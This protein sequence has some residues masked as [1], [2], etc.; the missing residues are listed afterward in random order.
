MTPSQER[1]ALK[2]IKDLLDA[3]AEMDKIQDTKL[4]KLKK[5]LSALEAIVHANHAKQEK[6]EIGISK[7]KPK[8]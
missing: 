7:P 5:R 8:A 4:E 2:N 1:Q 3:N 6:R